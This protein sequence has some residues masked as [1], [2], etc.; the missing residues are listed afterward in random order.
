MKVLSGQ[1]DI[2]IADGGSRDGS[3]DEDI[4]RG[5]SVNAL[6][7]KRDIGKLGSQ[8][9]M[10]FAWALQRGYKGIVIV[11]GNGKDNVEAIPSFISK[12]SAGFDHIQGSRFISGGYHKNTP[13]LRLMGLKLVHAPIMRRASGFPYTDTTN[14]FRAYSARLITDPRLALFRDVFTG[15]E[16]HYYIALKAAQL[17]FRCTE[18]PVGRVYPAHG[19]I[20]TKISPIKGNFQVLARLFAVVLGKYD[21]IT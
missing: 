12:L 11:D 6:L 18:I 15:Y 19:K 8:M 7:I 16:L 14:G 20:P 3:V 2:I 21:P 9:R 17:G 1:V 5:F 4:L 13:F 10:A